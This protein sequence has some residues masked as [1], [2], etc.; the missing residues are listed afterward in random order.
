M[1]T[2]APAATAEQAAH[3][4]V[5]RRFACSMEVPERFFAAHADAIAAACHAMAARFERGGRLFVV[6]VG[7][8]ASDAQHVAVEFVHPVLVGKRAL[9]AVALCADPVQRLALLGGADDIVLVLGGS[10]LSAAAVEALRLA[11]RRGMLSIA[12]SGGTTAPAEPADYGFHVP[13]ADALTVQET[14]ETLYH[15]L[16][17]TVHLFFERRAT[18]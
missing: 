10:G 9:P 2:V 7:G 3:A 14:H 12:L 17:E 16:W 18:A 5:R 1:S 6:G 8:A 4:L 11:A 13:D 15:V